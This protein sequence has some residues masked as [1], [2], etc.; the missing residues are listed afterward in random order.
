MSKILA[1]IENDMYVR[2]FITSGAF[3]SLIQNNDFG[4]CLSEIVKKLKSDVLKEK[5]V[6]YYKRSQE[7]I[8]LL[9]HINQISMRALRK[10]SST[11]D[12]KIRT[13]TFSPKPRLLYWLLSK[14]LIFKIAKKYFLAKFQNNYSLEKIIK[15]YQPKIVLFPVTGIEGT[16]VE[17]VKLSYRHGFKTFFLVNGWDN[18]SSKAVFPLL[19]D[20]L[21]VWG[22]QALVDAVNIQGMSVQRVFMLGCARYEDYFIAENA[23]LKLFP[24][25]YILFAGAT[26][27]CDEITPL[28]ILDDVLDKIGNT[29][30][31]IVYRPHP[32]R[33]KRNCF[34]DFDQ[35]EFKNVIIDPQVADN[36]YKEKKMGTESVSSQNFPQLKYYP[37]LLNNALFIISPMSSMTLEAALF[38]VPALI[39]AH[40]DN[41]HPIPPILQANYKHFEGAKEVPGWF[42]AY[43]LEQM[44][45]L[46]KTLLEQ[47]KDETPAK[48]KMRPVLCNA[49]KKYIIQDGRLYAQRL[50]EAIQLIAAENNAL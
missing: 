6:G 11:F 28:R 25:K 17:L 49:V 40:D 1:V 50:Q 38:D 8:S 46:F 36:Y 4:I 27:A 14:P 31:K 13:N 20:Y 33:Q 2:N 26:T 30:I 22:P 29:D 23:Q 45:N 19:P 34:D 43:D 48:R 32:W 35:R 18:L 5:I 21:G 41:C 3:N 7:N 47:F 42:F 24:Y 16:A 15:K 39:L 10:K 12:I 37:S 44:R 9:S